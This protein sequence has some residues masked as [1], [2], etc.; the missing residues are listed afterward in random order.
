MVCYRSEAD[1]REIHQAVQPENAHYPS[2]RCDPH[3]A[4]AHEQKYGGQTIITV[5][6][7]AS[8]TFAAQR[9][10]RIELPLADTGLRVFRRGCDRKQ[11]KPD[12]ASH[13]CGRYSHA[14]SPS[15]RHLFESSGPPPTSRLGKSGLRSDR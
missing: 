8:T 5:F 6:G 1:R 4:G 12:A 15:Q 2:Y 13:D 3:R 10:Y 9:D 14:I 11:W 7:V